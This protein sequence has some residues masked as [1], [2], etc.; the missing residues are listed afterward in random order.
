MTHLQ[1]APTESIVCP[2]T[3]LVDKREKA[4]YRFDGI[5]ADA[6]Q[7]HRP[8]IVTAEWMH[9]A[10]GDYTISGLEHLVC[11]E[12]KSLADL[13]STLGQHRERFEREHE[14]M[15]AIVANGGRCCVAVEADWETAIHLPPPQSSLPSKIVFRTAI[16]WEIRYNVP[17]HFLPDRRFAEIYTFRF[18]E[19]FWKYY[20]AQQKELKKHGDTIGNDS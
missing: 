7:Q 2:F 18:L 16:S 8:I 17:W 5:R 11:I 20:Q 10:T 12:R 3:V 13:Y 19:K 1:S 9:L 14:R 15:A 6:S 4:P